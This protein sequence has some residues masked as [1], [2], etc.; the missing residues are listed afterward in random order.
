ME[1]SAYSQGVSC[2]PVPHLLEVGGTE[3]ED[4]ATPPVSG[5]PSVLPCTWVLGFGQRRPDTEAGRLE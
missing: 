5:H 3:S 1:S 4:P 2:L